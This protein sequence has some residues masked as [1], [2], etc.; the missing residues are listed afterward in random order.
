MYRF[1]LNFGSADRIDDDN[2]LRAADSDFESDSDSSDEQSWGNLDR[3][4]L[5]RI[6]S[7]LSR[8]TDLRAFCLVNK[9]WTQA[10]T[11]QLWA[12]PQFS[13]PEQLAAFLRVLTDCSH[14]YGPHIRG[15]RFTLT[16]HYDRHLMSP[17]YHD[18]DSEALD[19]ELPT[20]LEIAQ[21][22]HVLSTDPAILRSL[23]HG[24]DL[25]SPPLAFKFARA[26]SPIDAL[27]IYGFRLRDKH[28][29]N[30]LMRWRLRELNII[31]M[32]RKPLANLGFL[33][34][35]LR[36]VRSLRLESDVPLSADV[37][38]A[39]ALRLP[40]LDQLRIWA[41]DIAGGQL[42]RSLVS[43]PKHLRV[44]HLVGANSNV[45]DDLVQTVVQAST[46]LQS[47][48]VY[49]SNITAQSAYTALCCGRNL[50]HLELMRDGPEILNGPASE[51]L[52]AVVASKLNA[53]SLRNLA[54]SNALIAAAAGVVT[55][56]RTLYI[57]GTPCLEGEPLG[58][59]LGASTELVSIGLYDSSC[60]SDAALQGLS[61]GPSAEKLRVLLVRQCR[62]QSDGIERILTAL[63]NLKHFSVVGTE[64][65]QQLFTYELAEV[66][67][68]SAQDDQVSPPEIKRSFKT[69][70]PPDHFF[71]QSDPAVAA[72]S[73]DVARDIAAYSVVP[74]PPTPRTAWHSYS[75]RRFVPGLVAFANTDA[76]SSTRRV[77]AATV[78][79]DSTGPVEA[80]EAAN[81]GRLRSI[82]E[83]PPN[84]DPI[85]IHEGSD[86]APSPQSEH[87]ASFSPMN[88]TDSADYT[89]N[90]VDDKVGVDVEA[91]RDS[92]RSLDPKPVT[93]ETG[94]SKLA[95][96]AI[97]AA[98]IA[99][100]TAIAAGIAAAKGSA[101]SEEQAS[102]KTDQPVE[103]AIADAVAND[104][105]EPAAES[106]DEDVEPTPKGFGMA[107]SEGAAAAE[108]EVAAEVTAAAE[109]TD[110]KSAAGDV[111]LESPEYKDASPCAEENDAG[112]QVLGQL[113]PTKDE[114]T[115][116]PIAPVDSEMA[117]SAEDNAK[118]PDQADKD[119][120]SA[121]PEKPLAE[122]N[123]ADAAS[124]EVAVDTPAAEQP[125]NIEP[126]SDTEAGENQAEPEAV[127]DES[128]AKARDVPSDVVSVPSES[129]EP[130]SEAEPRETT[131]SPEMAEEATA[132]DAD[133]APVARD[134]VPTPEPN[135]PSQES[136][137]EPS[138]SEAHEEAVDQA[139]DPAEKDSVLD[140]PA[141]PVSEEASMPEV[142]EE[143]VTCDSSTNEPAAPE[144]EK[145]TEQ[146]D[147]SV[148]PEKIA[149]RPD[150][151]AARVI[152]ADEPAAF[153]PEETF[154]REVLKETVDEPDVSAAA[155][156]TEQID[157]SETSRKADDQ[158]GTP[159]VDCSAADEPAVSEETSAR[160]V[161]E[162]AAEQPE[163]SAVDDSA[164]D[165][166]VVPVPEE[167]SVLEA[168]EETVDE[169]DVPADVKATETPEKVVDQSDTFSTRDL[170]I[171]E[172]TV[173]E[174][175]EHTAPAAEESSI[176]EAADEI[177]AT[178]EAFEEPMEQPE[179]LVS[180]DSIVDESAAP[181]PE[182][183]NEQP[184]T[185]EASEEIAAQPDTPVAKDSAADEPVP[186]PEEAIAPTT[187]EPPVPEASREAVDELSAP[188]PEK[189]T[190]P[191]SVLP[192]DLPEAEK[193][194]MVATEEP[195]TPKVEDTIV[196]EPS[197]DRS[198]AAETDEVDD[199]PVVS[200]AEAV[201]TDQ[202][203]GSAVEETSTDKVV[204]EEPPSESATE[205]ESAKEPV[206]DND[207]APE[208]DETITVKDSVTDGNEPVEHVADEEIQDEPAVHKA[209][210]AAAD[211]PVTPVAVEPVDEEPST[212][213]ADKPEIEEL[214]APIQEGD[215]VAEPIAPAPEPAAA[216][217]PAESAVEELAVDDAIAPATKELV[218]GPAA[219]TENASARDL[220]TEAA[221]QGVPTSIA[222]TIAV[223]DSVEPAAE[224]SLAE[225]PT[226]EDLSANEPASPAAEK[227][228]VDD[229]SAPKEEPVV[230]E[231]SAEETHVPVVEKAAEEA[232]PAEKTDV[233]VEAQAE[234][235]KPAADET[236]ASDIAVEEPSVSNA[237]DPAIKDVVPEVPATEASID[238]KVVEPATEAPAIEQ[239][240][241]SKVDEISKGETEAPVAEGPVDDVAV[242]SIAEATD[243]PAAK[244]S[245]APE[246]ED[247]DSQ[248]PSEPVVEARSASP[249]AEEPIAN[250]SAEDTSEIPVSDPP[251]SEI[252]TEPATEEA[253][254]S[255]TDGPAA[256]KPDEPEEHDESEEHAA[257]KTEDIVAEE[258]I[259]S[260]SESLDVEEPAVE[261]PAAQVT[262]GIVDESLVSVAKD[263]AP[264]GDVAPSAEDSAKPESDEPV[265]DETTA[266]DAKETAIEEMA[267]PATEET[268]SE[269]PNV[270]EPVKPAEEPVGNDADAEE[271]AAEE[272][273]KAEADVKESSVSETEKV[274]AEEVNTPVTSDIAVNEPVSE[275]PPVPTSDDVAT[276]D[277][278]KTEASE[279][280][281]EERS[282][283][284]AKEYAA[285][286]EEVTAP[287]TSDNVVKE[288]PSAMEEPAAPPV[289][290]IA[291]DEP[292]AEE[293]AVDQP[294]APAAEAPVESETA[295]PVVDESIAPETKEEI[296]APTTAESTAED[297]V[298]PESEV[299][300]AKDPVAEE[301]VVS[302]A[303]NA[304]AEETD[305]QEPIAE[306]PAVPVE[307]DPAVSKNADL[308][309]ETITV[310]A[311]AESAVAEPVPEESHEP[312]A[313]EIASKEPVVEDSVEP[314]APAVDLP[315]AE[316]GTERSAPVAEE[317]TPEPAEN[318][319][320]ATEKVDVSEPEPVVV[321]APATATTE[322]DSASEAKG[323][324]A[325]EQ[326]VEVDSAM[327]AARD[328]VVEKDDTPAA[329]EAT[330]DVPAVAES[331]APATDDAVSKDQDESAE[332]TNA[333]TAS[334]PDEVS[335]PTLDDPVDGD[336]A[337]PKVCVVESPGLTEPAPVTMEEPAALN[338]DDPAS[339]YV[340]V[341]KDATAS[342]T[343]VD[344]EPEDSVAVETDAA[345][346]VSVSD[347]AT[348][349]I[350]EEK[351]AAVTEE[352][353]QLADGTSVFA[354]DSV[355]ATAVQE[356]ES[357][358]EDKDV[359]AST[360]PEVSDKEPADL[361]S[362]EQATE[363]VEE[364][365]PLDV[366]K[367]EAPYANEPDN[368]PADQDV[369]TGSEATGIEPIPIGLPAHDKYAFDTTGNAD[370]SDVA[371]EKPEAVPVDDRSVN[372]SAIEDKPESPS[373]P[374]KPEETLES[375]P[376][377]VDSKAEPAAAADSIPVIA[378][379][380]KE[381]LP[382][383]EPKLEDAT[384]IGNQQEPIPP[385]EP[386]SESVPDETTGAF[387][388][389]VG[390]LLVSEQPASQVEP[391]VEQ[392]VELAPEP[393]AEAPI[394]SVAEPAADAQAPE[395]D[396]ARSIIDNVEAKEPS[397]SPVSQTTPDD[398]QDTSM[399]PEPAALSG[400]MAEMAAG[401][402]LGL[403]ATGASLA[404]LSA[405]KDSDEA[406]DE[407]V[408]EPDPEDSKRSIAKSDPETVEQ[409]SPGGESSSSYEMVEHDP[410]NA[411][412]DRAAPAQEP[413]A[414]SLTGQAES[415]PHLGSLSPMV[416]E[417]NV[418]T[419]SDKSERTAPVVIGTIEAVGQEPSS[420]DLDAP[421]QPSESKARTEP[422]DQDEL[423]SSQEIADL[424]RSMTSG[425]SKQESPASAVQ[426]APAIESQQGR[427]MDDSPQSQLSYN[428][429]DS[430]ASQH[431]EDPADNASDRGLS[432]RDSAISMGKQQEQDVYSATTDEEIGTVP[433]DTQYKSM[434]EQAVPES[435]PT[436]SAF[437]TPAFPQYF[438]HPDTQ[439]F[440]EQGAGI[441][442]REVPRAS[443]TVAGKV[444]SGRSKDVLMELNI[445]TPYHGRQLLQLRANDFIDGKCE[446][447][448]EMF[449][450]VDLLPGMKTLVRGKV[451]RRLARRR[452]RALQAAAASA[453]KGK[454]PY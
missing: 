292:I 232:Q 220:A 392:S 127:A 34:H 130:V 337:E 332:K 212:P 32:P 363:P 75:A 189:S 21:G 343:P 320:T 5:Q 211:V 314:V 240:T 93:E 148:A 407:H 27:S 175:E 364:P 78:S 428:R 87:S 335:A 351:A 251:A 285:T 137:G 307:E 129:A 108:A 42:V 158:P 118:T 114:V 119:D 24:S 376:V 380:D 271:T 80:D 134:I 131:L 255:K 45:G 424:V 201:T 1:D 227:S 280:A 370:Q 377:D 451:E 284:E 49:G 9:D 301:P 354:T 171:D 183:A 322:M 288:E 293:G 195:V 409:R 248:Q 395:D 287:A 397:E 283:S 300:A 263:L 135:L 128:E 295:E 90:V 365:A 96:G 411:V 204:V 181:E 375:L 417:E 23:L 312:A 442:H 378:E 238:D 311:T 230:E 221:S 106:I 265:A 110:R 329:E 404:A 420:P 168:P 266:S 62:M 454:Q 113:S 258:P 410:E 355:L 15:I 290:D 169:P 53:L 166:L 40:V 228:A 306:Q 160:E 261:E 423:E 436:D 39:V 399:K 338:I 369:P 386:A 298:A 257:S 65:V 215:G 85:I 282:I 73:S 273:V 443:E 303:D 214:V 91:A 224:E 318:T 344:D 439:Q 402:S 44:F 197:T 435:E 140:K 345:E 84:F 205:Q 360:E 161:F 359:P 385:E 143:T 262:R 11:P 394:Q 341:S 72:A 430:Q 356:A 29:V 413:A 176:A 196:Q 22:K 453:A 63:P 308:A 112:L 346:E 25:T 124:R 247:P 226:L 174:P 272:L 71:C 101:E 218:E 299:P 330:A 279:L 382:V 393:A 398:V 366:R 4:L 18:G 26:C 425:S 187:E 233:P 194:D 264:E 12:Y 59:L 426:A 316:A 121:E 384:A 222:D 357:K 317:A 294:T 177:V 225:K 142:P 6:A 315:S 191:A 243:M 188:G 305:A 401:L 56:L 33:L 51:D 38:N 102:E 163:T 274:A 126:V 390:E 138:A 217:E 246:K 437:S 249:I 331:I 149:E 99:G 157:V 219:S 239:P 145:A 448:C 441:Q 449:D 276:E 120:V 164:T 389:S 400:N 339:E 270:E 327:P 89:P 269:N 321:D 421:G 452:E 325:E 202:P 379:E 209:E 286:E 304:I 57:S 278:V 333:D 35:N 88:R 147:V 192:V 244:E 302:T 418:D 374:A 141:A 186:T 190:E 70:Y 234:E 313:E 162:E 242:E 54:V 61:N 383:A 184:S 223:E 193:A 434:A 340:E 403:A 50:T 326:P 259:M 229:V 52:P 109:W 199:K 58:Q 66:A 159:A 297:P 268:A 433:T 64:T 115:E 361:P 8:Q 77:R 2:D 252:T 419:A 371:A 447:F 362:L 31:G 328:V 156:A 28:V 98:G 373:A 267:A 203:A 349:L 82:S 406:V 170:A 358:V 368:L 427:D 136:F 231:A 19:I 60:L 68:E 334:I 206:T 256:E 76:A 122:Q 107:N 16:S 210:D 30:E 414:H 281:V 139:D 20:L 422:V 97:A 388:R 146:A 86:Y 154:A 408:K 178:P 48:V 236:T 381:D 348:R 150:M 405:T 133:N 367:D 319:V 180:K 167:P 7:F 446:E 450:M 289:G 69:M 3:R 245:V 79:G 81:A 235:T 429:S 347:P 277:L 111:E 291:V 440:Q 415:A 438:S 391:V 387:A 105:T 396:K 14:V 208:M 17:Y 296:A 125:K 13:A 173:H 47:L 260:A 342:A 74:P 155:K 36:S 250:D 207:A 172:P 165:V 323:P 152:A 352:P 46:Q 432:K 275:E 144:S 200:T 100:A 445:E 94:M 310:P 55:R 412:E 43:A 237:E 241:E 116:A 117:D 123:E 324:V 104:I 41:P 185:L 416:P 92:S 153:V 37:W 132:P 10:A 431:P 444:K 309:E 372:A 103:E 182:K 350:A 216:A 151:S 95:G 253:A 83:Q 198:I 213:A 67:S 179:L 336:A 254:E 353:A